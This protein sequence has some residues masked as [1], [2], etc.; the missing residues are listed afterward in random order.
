MAIINLDVSKVWLQAWVNQDVFIMSFILW[1]G[2]EDQ[3]VYEI[4]V[5]QMKNLMFLYIVAFVREG[6]TAHMD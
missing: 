5:Y 2:H 1:S 3:N 4:K 6:L